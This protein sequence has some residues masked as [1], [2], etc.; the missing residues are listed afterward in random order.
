MYKDN[1]GSKQFKLNDEM[2]IDRL[3]VILGMSFIVITLIGLVLTLIGFRAYDGIKWFLILCGIWFFGGLAFYGIYGFIGSTVGYTRKIGSAPLSID[4][5]V[6]NVSSFVVGTKGGKKY[7]TILYFSDGFV[8]ITYKTD[9]CAIWGGYSI[10]KDAVLKSEILN[11]A[12]K[13]HQKALLRA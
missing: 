4:A 9:R 5:K 11:D 1:Y 12:F 8:Y 7:K 6:V 2:G 3:P 10:S 13:A